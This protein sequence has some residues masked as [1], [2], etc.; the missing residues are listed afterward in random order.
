MMKLALLLICFLSFPT[1]LFAWAGELGIFMDAAGT[2]CDLNN[3]HGFM[4]V[5]VVH[6]NT[7][8]ATGVYFRVKVYG[9]PLTWYGDIS[10]YDL[11]GDSQS[12]VYVNYGSCTLAPIDVM[13]IAYVGISDPCDYVKVIGHSDFDPPNTFAYDC[14]LPNPNL[15]YTVHDAGL[16]N[17]NGSCPCSAKVVPIEKSTWG[18]VKALYQ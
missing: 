7:P 15:L 11:I 4:Q 6:R 1:I 13:T 8:G 16:I 17:N 5:H 14:V 9:A 10:Q 3:S 12:G 18:K 2:T